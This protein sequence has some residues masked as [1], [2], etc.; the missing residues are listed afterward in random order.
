MA[1]SSLVVKG[2]GWLFCLSQASLSSIQALRR[3]HGAA[4]IEVW[5]F[6]S[7]M[8]EGS[9]GVGERGAML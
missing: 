5:L 7:A 2:A 3:D 1:A 8:V 6:G 4:W 9:E